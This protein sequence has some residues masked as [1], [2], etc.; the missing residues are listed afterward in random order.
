MAKP[1]KVLTE[2]LKEEPYASIL[3]YPKV[4][5]VEL[6]NRLEELR[7]LGVSAVEFSG[8]SSAFDVPVLG[9]GFVGVVVTAHLNRQRAALKIRRVDAGRPSLQHEAEMLTKANSITVGPRLIGASKNFILMQLIDGTPLPAWLET[10]TAREEVRKVLSDILEQCWRL[11]RAGLDHGELSKAPKHLIVDK[12]WKPWIVDFETASDT[13]KPANVAAACHY[14]FIGAVG[15][16]VSKVLG[17]RNRTEI[18]EA[19]RLYKKTRIRES[20]DRV[21]RICLG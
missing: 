19:L 6:Q 20:F 4:S 5:N 3:C 13:R 8:R 10:H 11:D 1:T 15:A 17:E 14:L 18:I 7:A 9:K 2:N 21:L 12:T 16:A